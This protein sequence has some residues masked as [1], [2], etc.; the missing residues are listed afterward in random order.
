MI[1]IIGNDM[2]VRV[3]VRTI[4]NKVSTKKDLGIIMKVRIIFKRELSKGMRMSLRIIFNR[5]STK[6]VGIPL[7]PLVITLTIPYKLRRGGPIVR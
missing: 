3:R 5:I 2:G 6:K 4:I 1:I 7:P